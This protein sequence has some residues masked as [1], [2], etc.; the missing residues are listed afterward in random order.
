MGGFDAPG[1][2]IEVVGAI[3]DILDGPKG[4]T[5]IGDSH[6][7]PRGV[8]W[9]CQSLTTQV[10]QSRRIGEVNLWKITFGQIG[11][12]HLEAL[13]VVFCANPRLY[14]SF[15][16]YRHKQ[17]LTLRDAGDETIDGRLEAFK[18]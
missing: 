10:L 15:P 5:F 13:Y 6:E 1:L 7:A 12:Q 4:E 3:A 8:G 17:A 11:F 18:E 9:Q 16:E 14:A 2:R